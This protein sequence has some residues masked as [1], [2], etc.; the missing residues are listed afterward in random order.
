MRIGRVYFDF[1]QF[2]YWKF[3]RS[4]FTRLRDFEIIM[5]GMIIEIIEGP[6]KCLGSRSRSPFLFCVFDRQQLPQSIPVSS[7]S[8]IWDGVP[9]GVVKWCLCYDGGWRAPDVGNLF[10]LQFLVTNRRFV[11]AQPQVFYC[12]DYL[13]ALF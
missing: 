13:L 6:I 9:D 7:I 3:F 12:R 2:T 4:R 1:V 8:Q 11:I 10:C 5:D